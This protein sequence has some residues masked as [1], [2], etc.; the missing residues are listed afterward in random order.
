ME[1]KYNLYVLL[2][3]TQLKTGKFIRKF[4][5]FE[6]N[7]CSISF[8]K[9][10]KTLYSFSRKHKN[11]TFYAGLVKESSLRYTEDNKQTKVQIFKIPLTPKTYKRL[12]KYL[13]EL[14]RHEEEYIYN[15]LSLMTYPFKKKVHVQKA[16]TCCEFT[17][18]ILRD[19]CKMID[20]GKNKGYC[21]IQE[22]SEYLK[23]YLIYEGIY[24]VENDSWQTDKYL[25][26][27]NIFFKTIKI[28][29]LFSSLIYRYIKGLIK[30]N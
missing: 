1:K 27:Q 18:H 19:F 20:L 26:R 28:T 15:Y 17:V 22:L 3:K 14:E 21:S 11:S 2:T 10:F 5:R 8:D 23:E 25:E 16:Y 4:T 29:E 30:P 9:N 6:Y 24:N 7:H 13:N 12:N